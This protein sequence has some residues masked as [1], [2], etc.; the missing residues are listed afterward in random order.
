MTAEPT[1]SACG[2]PVQRTLT[3]NGWQ[4]V[5]LQI[6]IPD[7]RRYCCPGTATPHVH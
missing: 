1:C 6:R 2:L 7:P 5:A 4:W 3:V